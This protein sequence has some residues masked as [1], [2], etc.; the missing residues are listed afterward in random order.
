MSRLT[1]MELGKDGLGY[2]ESCLK[3]W[4]GLSE[5]A[6]HLPLGHGKTI[7]LLP[8]GTPIGR[9]RN[10]HVGGLGIGTEEVRWLTEHLLSLRTRHPDSAVIIQD[11][12]ALSGDKCIQDAADRKFFHKSHVYYFLNSDSFNEREIEDIIYTSAGVNVV[13]FFIKCRVDE[14]TVLDREVDDATFSFLSERIEEVFV[15]AYD[16]ESLVIWSP[17]NY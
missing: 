6:L 13:G 5:M 16:R 14:A 8:P 3:G 11:T 1:E 15:S 10:F 4:E 7:A 12:T 9:A 17:P 2:V